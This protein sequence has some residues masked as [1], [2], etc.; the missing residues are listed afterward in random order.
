MIR[1]DN[2]P[3]TKSNIYRLEKDINP[4][5]AGNKT[6]Q[7]HHWEGVN[8]GVKEFIGTV[9]HQTDRL[10]HAFNVPGYQSKV[11]R[12]AF[13]Q[14]KRGV[15]PKIAEYLKAKRKAALQATAGR[16]ARS[17][18]PGVAITLMFTDAANAQTPPEVAA[19]VVEG[20]IGEL[21]PTPIPIEMV[22]A[23]GIRQEVPALPD[24]TNCT[25]PWGCHIAAGPAWSRQ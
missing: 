20:V 22:L 21:N 16:V 3:A 23:E 9:R 18:A 4:R 10:L 7:L 24:V 6:A 25:T 17:V 13:A 2:I 14:F 1:V 8:L 12:D 11:D 15:Y 19:A 5:L